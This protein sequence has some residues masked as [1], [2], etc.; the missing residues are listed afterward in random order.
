METG[1]SGQR[2]PRRLSA[3]AVQQLIE[4]MSDSDNILS[5]GDSPYSS[6]S[7]SDNSSG[8]DARSRISES[9]TSLLRLDLDLR[10]HCL[11]HMER[12]FPYQLEI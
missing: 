8:S 1:G 5:D 4:N 12:S 6:H 7:D 3:L 2:P 11:L 10:G 9:E